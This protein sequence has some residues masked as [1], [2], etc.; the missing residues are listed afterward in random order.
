MVLMTEGGAADA[1]MEGR[2][3]EANWYLIMT[4]THYVWS[5]TFLISLPLFFD[6]LSSPSLNPSHIICDWLEP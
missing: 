3:P 5:G 2:C 4:G 1:G 6:N